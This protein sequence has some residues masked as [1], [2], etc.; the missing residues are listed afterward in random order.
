MEAITVKGRLPVGIEVDGKLYRD[1]S[2][3][4]GTLRDA[5]VAVNS[6][7][8]GAAENVLRYAR[9]AQCVSFDGLAQEHVTLDLLMGLYERDAVALEVASDEVEKK[10]DALSSS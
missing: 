2:M 4:A 1:F 6:A 3:R 8:T 7:P 9:M 10:L 5:C